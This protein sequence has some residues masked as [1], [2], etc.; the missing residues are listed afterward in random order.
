MTTT[1]HAHI[2][3]A[4]ADCD[5]PM[6]REY[7]V[8]LNDDEIAQHEAAEANGGVNDFHDLEFKARVLSSQVSFHSEFGVTVK[9]DSDGFEM[10]EQTDEGYRSSRVVWCEDETCD[11]EAYGQRDVYAE[12]MGY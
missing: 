2:D 12:M 11:P 10:H 3:T 6:Y 5:G 7:V 1:L 8:T 9:L 4:S